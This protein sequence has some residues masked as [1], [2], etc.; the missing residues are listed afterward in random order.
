MQVTSADG[1]P[2]GEVTAHFSPTLKVGIGLALLDRTSRGDT[3]SVD[4]RGRSASMQV[5]KRRRPSH[6]R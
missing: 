4:I 3:V 2:V 5:V 6:V 1:A